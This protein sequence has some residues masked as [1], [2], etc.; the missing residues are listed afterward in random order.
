MDA[1]IILASV[2]HTEK[3]IHW[4]PCVIFPKSLCGAYPENAGAYFFLM[5]FDQDVWQFFIKKWKSILN[6]CQNGSPVLSV[7]VG[8]WDP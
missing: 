6:A 2:S 5:F 4:A 3:K 8:P 1:G 7:T